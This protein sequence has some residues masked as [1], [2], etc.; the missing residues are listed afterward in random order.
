MRVLA[1]AAALAL[2][3]AVAGAQRQDDWRERTI[4]H[5]PGSIMD[6]RP[7][8]RRATRYRGSLVEHDR[9]S[10]H[11]PGQAL[12][13]PADGLPYQP[14]AKAKQEEFK[15]HLED[16]TR[17]EYVEPLRTMRT[18]WADQVVSVARI[19]DPAVPRLCAV[20]VRL[21]NARDPPGR[22]DTPARNVEVVERRFAR[23]LG[24]ALP[25]RRRG[26][27]Q[28]EGA[29]RANRRVRQRP[30]ARGRA[31]HV[32]SGGRALHVSRDLHRPG[33]VDPT[34]HDHDSQPSREAGHPA[35]RVEQPHVS[36]G[37]FGKRRHSFA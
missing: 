15:A 30:G 12:R 13:T 36:G 16:P 23:P 4:A 11:A 3:P 32:R 6:W 24:R 14:W 33:D 26:Q 10:Q 17:P 8:C 31:V 29:V 7:N 28:F 22:R 19:R 18:G 20:P 37:V 1:L 25:R 35:G 9:E 27:Q 21:G 2:L 5:R 34:V